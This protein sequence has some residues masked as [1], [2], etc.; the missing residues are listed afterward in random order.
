MAP[1]AFAYSAYRL[2]LA[3]PFRDCSSR[4][5]NS[6]KQDCPVENRDVVTLYGYLISLS[7]SL[8]D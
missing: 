7:L 4:G 3:G 8:S 1:V 5:Q 6:I 2:S